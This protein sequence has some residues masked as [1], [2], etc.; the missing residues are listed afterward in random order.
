MYSMSKEAK[1]GIIAVFVFATY[2]FAA[3]N[4]TL[5]G[6]DWY[7]FHQ[8]QPM[9]EFFVQ[10]NRWGA[11]VLWKVF[12]GDSIV[13]P[14][15]ISILIVSLIVVSMRLC[16]LLDITDPIHQ[17]VFCCLF[18]ACPI[19]IEH[20]QF[21]INHVLL[22]F[23]LLAS[24]ISI[25]RLLNAKPTVIDY[26][27]SVTLL[28]LAFGTLQVTSVFF[29]SIVIFIA[30]DR[31]TLTGKYKPHI[32]KIFPMAGVA[33]IALLFSLLI[34]T[35]LKS[36]FDIPDVKAA[37]IHSLHLVHD[38][39]SAI[40]SVAMFSIYVVNF[41]IGDQAGWSMFP[42]L[43]FLTILVLFLRKILSGSKQFTTVLVTLGLVVLFLLL[44][45]ALGLVRTSWSSYR[46]TAM[47]PL[48]LIY[49][50]IIGVVLR[51]CRD[52]N[53]TKVVLI[54][55]GIILL[56][57]SQSHNKATSLNPPEFIKML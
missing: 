14:L 49:P 22:A 24:I 51:D 32:Q 34:G 1:Y 56:Q 3:F 48:M 8:S 6:D 30:L 47:F 45:F 53:L 29:A 19:L 40:D 11:L 54:F 16:K 41:Y 27:I 21:K 9:Q 50:L 17:I 25:E 2:G 36:V 52:R 13:A 28:T 44:P 12:Y 35:V 5:A 39:A 20:I 38:L 23:C 43:I 46:Y 15:S 10:I 37:D 18:L 31:F 7:I 4:L 33:L 55:A 26:L 42:K 57:F